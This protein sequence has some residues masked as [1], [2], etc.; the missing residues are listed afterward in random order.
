MGNLQNLDYL[1]LNSN[2]LTCS[3]PPTIFNISTIKR[4]TLAEQQFSGHFPSTIGHSLP[5]MEG[6]TPNSITNASKLSVLDLSY[7]SFFGLILNTFGSLKFLGLLN[8]AY[9]YLTTESSTGGLS[10]LPS[11]NSCRMLAFLGLGFNPL[12]GIPSTIN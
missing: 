3:I 1:A 4:I 2:N 8:L 7:N 11:L 9:N 5:N 12:R 10:F 6:T